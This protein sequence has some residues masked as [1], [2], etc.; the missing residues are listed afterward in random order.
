AGRR[1]RITW[2]D[3][4]CAQ[5]AYDLAN[6]VTQISAEGAGCTTT[7]L[8][9]YA[10]DNLGRRTSVSRGNSTSETVSFN[11]AGLVSSLAQD[12][13]GTSD[14]E[15]LT[16]SYNA[17][18]GIVSRAGS[19]TSYAWSPIAAGTTSYADNGLNQ[20]TSVGG[21][22]QAHDSRGNLTTGSFG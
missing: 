1:T 15:T 11:D 20:Y 19:N 9:T 18:G 14:D 3:S 5:Y 16:Y 10:Y 7:T 6:A 21:T 22:S 8:A 4:F 13:S 2:P 17:A 12:L